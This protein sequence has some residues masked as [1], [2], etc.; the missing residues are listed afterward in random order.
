M[1]MILYKYASTTY[2]TWV[3]DD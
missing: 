3:K 2:M 1:Y